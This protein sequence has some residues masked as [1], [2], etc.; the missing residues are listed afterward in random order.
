MQETRFLPA[1]L[2][3]QNSSKKTKTL[4]VASGERVES[5]PGRGVSADDGSA[6]R[7]ARLALVRQRRPDVEAAAASAR[8]LHLSRVVAALH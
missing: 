8:V 6:S 3:E 5:R 4:T 2:T 1:L 7:V